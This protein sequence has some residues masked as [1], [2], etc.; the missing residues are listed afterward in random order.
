MFYGKILLI[1]NISTKEEE[2][3]NPQKQRDFWQNQLK[4]E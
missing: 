1:S 3:N 4:A 2:K